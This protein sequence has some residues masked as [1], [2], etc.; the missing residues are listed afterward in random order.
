MGEIGEGKT[1]SL[2]LV[3]MTANMD[4]ERALSR[5]NIITEGKVIYC[6]IF[7][8]YT[9]NSNNFTGKVQ[10]S[11]CTISH[12]AMEGGFWRNTEELRITSIWAIH[13][14]EG[15]YELGM[16]DLNKGSESSTGQFLGNLFWE[17]YSRIKNTSNL[18][19]I[20]FLWLV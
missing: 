19:Q 1:P 6:Y 8:I 13:D 17:I 2:L 5:L 4:H 3:F 14:P 7:L 10:Y 11:G 12:G 16:A 20:L 15:L 18:S 9:F